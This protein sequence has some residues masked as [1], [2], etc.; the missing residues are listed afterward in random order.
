M[1]RKTI[2]IVPGYRHRPTQ[3]AYKEISKIL[4][5][6]GYHTVP[7]TM[8]WRQTTISENMEYLVKRY[9]RI[10]SK[11]KYI[12]GFSLGA[13]IAFIASTKV[14]SSGLILCSLSPYFKEDLLKVNDIKFS[15][16]S[17]KR[18]QYKDFQQLSSV[19]LAKEIKAKKVLMLYG[20]KEAK[21]LI[22]R[23]TQTYKQIS[24]VDK[25][26]ISIKE[27]EHNIADKRYLTAIHQ[28]A[29]ELN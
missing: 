7:I 15:A 3:R 28:V 16:T 11:K 23:V 25:Y 20:T 19:A 6:E 14:R 21:S 26:L 27:T 2:F 24:S 5:G 13:M 12:L 1:K 22:K 4:K 18:L 29:K 8:P 10:K 17:V 9:K